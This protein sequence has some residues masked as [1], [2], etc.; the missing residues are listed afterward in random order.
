MRMRIEGPK[1]QFGS[2]FCSHIP[3]PNAKSDNQPIPMC[4][5][6]PGPTTPQQRVAQRQYLEPITPE[7][8]NPSL[9]FFLESIYQLGVTIA[10]R[11][12]ELPLVPFYWC[13]F[14]DNRSIISDR[15]IF[16]W[17]IHAVREQGLTASNFRREDPTG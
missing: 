7:R 6:H 5:V 17:A 14:C 1:F 8:L 13:C 11:H 3:N 15:C 9:H 2:R 16:K 4:V 10:V 12:A